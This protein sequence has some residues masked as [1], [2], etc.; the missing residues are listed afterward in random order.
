M[1]EHLWEYV[2][3]FAVV[4]FDNL[5]IEQLDIKNHLSEEEWNQFFMGDDSEF[6]YYIDMVNRQFAKSSAAPFDERYP[7]MDSCDDMFEKIRKRK[8]ES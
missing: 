4:S 5:A 7:L 8:H 1:K 2:S 6:T 3:K